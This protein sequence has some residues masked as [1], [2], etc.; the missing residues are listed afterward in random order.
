M[1]RNT[2]T[3]LISIQIIYFGCPLAF[4][5]ICG[6]VHTWFCHD[7]FCCSIRSDYRISFVCL[8]PRLYFLSQDGLQISFNLLSQINTNNFFQ[9]PQSTSIFHYHTAS[10]TSIANLMISSRSDISLLHGRS[11]S[12]LIFNILFFYRWTLS[13]AHHLHYNRS[14]RW[15]ELCIIC[16][17]VQ[18]TLYLSWIHLVLLLIHWCRIL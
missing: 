1:A 4:S 10:H 7:T 13:V 16:Y 15:Q 17:A 9:S 5:P 8:L 12:S 18:L 6:V 3:T 2:Q 14:P 11:P